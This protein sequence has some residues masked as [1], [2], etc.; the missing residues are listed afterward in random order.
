[1]FCFIGQTAPIFALYSYEG[2]EQIVITIGK[3]VNVYY[4]DEEG[5]PEEGNYI[6]FDVAIDDG[7]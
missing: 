3:E 5:F 2:E 7:E 1:M 4:E 6:Q